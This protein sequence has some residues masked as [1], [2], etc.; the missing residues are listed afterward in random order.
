[1]AFFASDFD[2]QAGQRVP[3]LGMIEPGSR[4]PI[5]EVVALGA[6]RAQ[7][8]AVRILV[9]GH[10]ILGQAQPGAGHILDFDLRALSGENIRWRVALGAF[11]LRVLSF[12]NVSRLAV[13]EG[14]DRP[15]PV[16]L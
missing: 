6:I 3:R 2:V 4:L 13:V 11:D 9:A 16:N 12:Q 10:A 7:P 1:M 8:A 15:I 5:G 14:I